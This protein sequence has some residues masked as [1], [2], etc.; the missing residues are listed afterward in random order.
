[1]KNV[2]KMHGEVE[3][4]HFAEKSKLKDNNRLAHKTK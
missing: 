3:M 2:T 1:M 4:M